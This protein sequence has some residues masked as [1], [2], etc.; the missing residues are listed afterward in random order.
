MMT[1]ENLSLFEKSQNGRHNELNDYQP[2]ALTSVL[3]KCMERLV[4]RK[5]KE[6]TNQVVDPLQFA[7]R[8][9][10]GV[11]DAELTKHSHTSITEGHLL[12]FCL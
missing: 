9:N 1:F 6:E 3:M 11:E 8:H 7:Y 12:G 4:L 10:R 2:I 5:P